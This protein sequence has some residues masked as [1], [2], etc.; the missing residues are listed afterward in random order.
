MQETARFDLAENLAR[1]M[2]AQLVAGIIL[3]QAPAF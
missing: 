3:A 1:L 2:S